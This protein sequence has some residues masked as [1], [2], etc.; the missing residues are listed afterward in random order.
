VRR[1][2]ERGDT[3]F[4]EATLVK[5]EGCWSPREKGKKGKPGHL[6]AKS[7]VSESFHPGVGSKARGATTEKVEEMW[8]EAMA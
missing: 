4:V 1:K 2:G 5:G 3:R 6:E 7:P 8:G